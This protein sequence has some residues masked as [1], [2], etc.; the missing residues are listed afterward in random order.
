MSTDFQ[1]ILEGPQDS[2]VFHLNLL[3]PVWHQG[4]LVGVRIRH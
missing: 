1:H 2:V 4:A 3:A